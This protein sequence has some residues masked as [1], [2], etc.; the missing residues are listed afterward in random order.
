MAASLLIRDG[1]EAAVGH[2]EPRWPRY[3]T[4][5]L[6]RLAVARSKAHA[7]NGLNQPAL[8]I[9]NKLAAT[10][11]SYQVMRRTCGTLRRC[12]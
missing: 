4:S 11:E 6:E 9:V 7:I 12:R 2:E 1:L 3:A 8:L 5:V 10:V